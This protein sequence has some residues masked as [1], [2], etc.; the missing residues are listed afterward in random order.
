MR[1]STRTRKT[2]RVT[3]NSKSMMT[4]LPVRALVPRLKFRKLL[5]R[6]C[7]KLLWEL[8]VSLAG[9]DEQRRFALREVSL[10]R[11]GQ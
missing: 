4:P 5:V 10:Q 9:V 1:P 8:R 7:S 3:A 2:N 11:N 6:G